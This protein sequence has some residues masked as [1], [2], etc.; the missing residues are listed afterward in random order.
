MLPTDHE[1]ELSEII[2]LLCVLSG[3]LLIVLVGAW[4]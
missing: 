2:G 1:H 3:A 4:L